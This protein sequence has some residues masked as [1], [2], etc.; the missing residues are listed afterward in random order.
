MPTVTAGD[1]TSARSA[2]ARSCLAPTKTRSQTSANH[3]VA[4]ATRPRAR[5]ASFEQ[6]FAVFADGDRRSDR[7]ARC[8]LSQRTARAGVMDNRFEAPHLGIQHALAVRREREVAAPLVVFVGGRPVVRL[9]DEIGLLELAK[10][11]VQRRGPEAHLA[12]R[13]L[14][15]LLH[16][17]VAM[18]RSIGH[19][20]QNVEHLRLERQQ[21]IDAS[22]LVRHDVCRRVYIQNCL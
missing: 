22:Q 16:D 18:P 10:Q 11:S 17:A 4:S 19:R 5:A 21:P 6:P 15:H 9:H 12:V 8:G 7:H 3:V 1:R 20:Q 14:G 2:C 13:A